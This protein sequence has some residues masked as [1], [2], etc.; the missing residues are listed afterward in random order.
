MFVSLVILLSG[1]RDHD[2]IA[3]PFG[4]LTADAIAAWQRDCPNSVEHTKVCGRAFAT[5][6][7]NHLPG[8]VDGS[9]TDN[10]SLNATQRWQCKAQ[11]GWSIWTDNSK[12]ILG[13]CVDEPGVPERIPD[14][15]G[16]RLQKLMLRNMGHRVVDHVRTNERWPSRDSTRPGEPADTPTWYETPGMEWVRLYV[17]DIIDYVG[18]TPDRPDGGRLTLCVAYTP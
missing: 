3:T 12:H 9:Y 5:P 6:Y 18:R 11:D 14:F 13:L 16:S 1:C 4:T 2:G 8:G 15:E 17:P 10:A 7:C